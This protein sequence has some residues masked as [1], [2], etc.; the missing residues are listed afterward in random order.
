MHPMVQDGAFR[1]FSMLGSSTACFEY[2]R[3]LLAPAAAMLLKRLAEYSD[4][5]ESRPMLYGEAGVRYIVDLNSVGRPL[6][7]KLIDPS[8]SAT[9]RAKHGQRRL[10]PQ[11]Q[12][13]RGVKPILF[14]DKAEYT[15][16][17]ASGS[18]KHDARITKCHRAYMNLFSRCAERTGLPE[19]R[20]VWHFLAGTPLSKLELGEN[21]DGAAA[22]T[23]RV[24]GVF[25]SD[26][27]AVQRFWA[28]EHN[29][30]SREARMMQCIVCGETRPVLS[31]LQAK[32]KGIPGGQTSGTAIISANAD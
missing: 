6:S 10:M 7:P 4:R 26:L 3:F 8:N 29:P 32:I 30:D 27:P 2:H 16:G 21:F 1:A 25:P 11:I 13:S 28:D 15:L 22:L 19:V 31:R 9:P 18:S 20:A 23:F 17:I 12:R 24:N 14:A 5:L